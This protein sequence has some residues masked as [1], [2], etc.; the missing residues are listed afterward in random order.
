MLTGRR[1][2]APEPLLERYPELKAIADP[3]GEGRASPSLP[4]LG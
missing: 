4:L 2:V 3:A 1:V